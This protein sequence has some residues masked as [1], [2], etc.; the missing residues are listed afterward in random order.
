M[1]KFVRNV[2]MLAGVVLLVMGCKEE[3]LEH[4]KTIERSKNYVSEEAVK[5]HRKNA[6]N[7]AGALMYYDVDVVMATTYS[8]FAHEV[9]RSGKHAIINDSVYTVIDL[10]P[11]QAVIMPEDQYMGTN[12]EP[13]LFYCTFSE[14]PS[15]I[16]MRI[17]RDCRLT[18]YYKKNLRISLIIYDHKNSNDYLKH[19]LDSYLA[20][21]DQY[22]EENAGFY[23]SRINGEQ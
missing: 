14:R 8:K 2:L 3:K 17:N 12:G 19:K 4:P 9:E 18:F 21:V 22:L 15:S 16:G 23:Y 1:Q 7:V 10:G 13:V 20:R 6:A 11:N 5:E